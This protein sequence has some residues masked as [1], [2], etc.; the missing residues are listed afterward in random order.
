MSNKDRVTEIC[1][2]NLLQKVA[3]RTTCLREYLQEEFYF[4][5]S[6]KSVDRSYVTS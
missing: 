2:I 5:S 1:S 4:L 6:K 3:G